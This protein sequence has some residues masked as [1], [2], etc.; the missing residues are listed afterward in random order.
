MSDSDQAQAGTP[1]GQ[2]P[3]EIDAD[4]ARHLENKREDLFEKFEMPNSASRRPANGPRTS[5][6]RF[7]TNSTSEPTCAS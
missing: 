5:R 2:G 3:V 7:R 4:L 1:E 6:P